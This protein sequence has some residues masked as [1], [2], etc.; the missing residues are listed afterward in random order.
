MLARVQAILA[1][2]LCFSPAGAGVL[3]TSDREIHPVFASLP[4]GLN[5]HT[6]GCEGKPA[7]IEAPG[8]RYLMALDAPA[9]Q[10]PPTFSG[11]NT[12]AVLPSVALSFTEAPVVTASRT[13]TLPFCRLRDGPP[14]QD[15]PRAPPI[16][17][18]NPRH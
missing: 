11:L 2:L 6:Q 8:D 4:F 5:L 16:V 15:S 13:F 3:D 9:V 1:L 17:T 14:G 12:G 18:V 10:T 7:C